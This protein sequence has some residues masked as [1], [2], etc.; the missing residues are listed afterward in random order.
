MSTICS[1]ENA[2]RKYYSRLFFKCTLIV[3]LMSMTK[4][5]YFNR[6]SICL[7][8]D[9]YRRNTIIQY[10]GYKHIFAYFLNILMAHYI[11]YL[12]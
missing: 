8:F 10:F 3:N 2:W 4:Q 6:K 7:V 5:L 1:A 11:I 9:I 12:F